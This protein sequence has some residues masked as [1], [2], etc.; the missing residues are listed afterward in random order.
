MLTYN[1]K[2]VT[3]P[4]GKWPE[5]P[6]IL[7]AYT[8]RLKFRAGVTPSF[9]DGTAV[10]V[11]ENPNIWDLTY[12]NPS[13]QILLQGQ[14]DLLAVLGAGDTSGVTHMGGMFGG[15]TALQYIYPMDTSNVTTMTSMFSYCRSL[16][17][18]PELNTSSVVS[19]DNM[20]LDCTSI[21]TVP[22]FDTSSVT[23]MESMFTDCSSLVSVP[24]FDTSS[25][26]NMHTMF[27]Y[28][29]S[30]VAVPLFDTSS[31]VNMA[32]MFFDCFA[33]QSGALALYQQ[34]STQTTVPA[35]YSNCFT[36]CGRDTTT[37]AAELAQIPSSWGGTGA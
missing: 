15:C 23:T 18:V 35:Y 29:T 17:E 3:S 20:F 22:L 12:E 11:K 24:L 14:T 19:M 32:G 36:D 37:G 7:P 5:P 26:T 4:A 13:W 31:A 27:S 33:V 30:L 6:I 34:A 10:Q 25:V 9:W 28:C 16:R 21:E 2:V 1:G 8:L